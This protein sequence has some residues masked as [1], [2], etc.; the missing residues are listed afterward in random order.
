MSANPCK[1]V[2]FL[3]WLCLTCI[4][5]ANVSHAA[6]Q[7]GTYVG[8]YIG[9]DQ[10]AATIKVNSNGSVTCELSS[11]P[12]QKTFVGSTGGVQNT[13]PFIFNCQGR[14]ES[15]YVLGVNGGE[16]SPN[17]PSD[18]ISGNWIVSYGGGAPSDSGSYTAKLV[19]NLFSDLRVQP[20]PAVTGQVVN[21][22][23]LAKG[24][25]LS[26]SEGATVKVEGS[27]V[28]VS[29]IYEKTC[30]GTPPPPR[31]VTVPLGIFATGAYTLR[32][33]SIEETTPNPPIDIPFQVTDGLNPAAISGLW[34]DPT[35]S[36]SG[37]SILASGAGL[38]VTY[39]GWDTNG[40][41]LWLISDT[42]P[43]KI[44]PGTTI[45]LPMAQGNG[46]SFSHPARNP[47]T[48]GTLT[49]KFNSCSTATA[50]LNGTDGQ[51]N[52]NL[53]LLAGVGNSNLCQ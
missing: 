52:Q 6:R 1:S 10:G 53:V 32:F 19:N 13:E 42:G 34:Y 36:G 23:F 31:E 22:V 27:V 2:S 47:T 49:L 26:S 24:C 46:G 15:G 21:F 14:A 17:L 30:W 37:F 16:S 41:R 7:V 51:Q 29:T 4:L 43:K 25:T 35:Y 5:F 44:T 50:T 3:V 40:G 48:W 45:T 18:T 9:S 38:L 12:Q 11:T 39:Y 33:V 8:N 20:N 28:N